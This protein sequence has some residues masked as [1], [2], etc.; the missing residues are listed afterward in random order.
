MDMALKCCVV[1][2]LF[3]A[4]LVI[5]FE[6]DYIWDERFK[7]SL[8]RAESGQ[9]KNQ[10]VV[11]DMYLKGRGTVIDAKQALNWFL[12]AAKQGHRRA[13][14]KVAYLYLYDDDIIERSPQRALRWL[15]QAAEAGFV[16]AKFEL[17]KLYASGAAGRRDTA[18]ALKWLGE[19]KLAGYEPAREEFARLVRRMVK[20]SSH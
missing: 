19:A 16:P 18:L 6:G 2:L 10:Y 11:G 8:A 3:F 17:G 7:A 20:D 1:L 14:Y 15:Q 9:A 13:A 12:R 4:Q 5:A